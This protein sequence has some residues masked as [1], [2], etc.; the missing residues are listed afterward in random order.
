ML[1]KVRK[2]G[3]PQASQINIYKYLY[4]KVSETFRFTGDC[5]MIAQIDV[6]ESTYFSRDTL[7]CD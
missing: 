4:L 1:Y 2:P 6:T 5:H 3:D 7:L